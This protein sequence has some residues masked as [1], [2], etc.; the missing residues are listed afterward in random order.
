MTIINQKLKA[1][2]FAVLLAVL[3]V[4]LG[5]IS[6]LQDTSYSDTPKSISTPL[7]VI[8]LVEAKNFAEIYTYSFQDK[9]TRLLYTDTDEEYKLNNI[10]SFD[11]TAKYLLVQEAKSGY[12]WQRLT[13]INLAD[14]TK[15]VLKD[16]FPYSFASGDIN[17]NNIC[18]LQANEG[19]QELIVSRQTQIA[20]M[21]AQ[22]DQVSTSL[23]CN[24]NTGNIIATFAEDNIQVW[25]DQW[26][27]IDDTKDSITYFDAKSNIVYYNRAERIFAYNTATKQNNELTKFQHEPLSFYIHDD[28]MIYLYHS[29]DSDSNAIFVDSDEEPLTI[30]ANK[31]IGVIL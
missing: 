19:R 14:A 22:W 16:E 28:F 23:R 11:P 5:S 31:I 6:Y 10:V 15:T 7:E 4:V 30:Q 13:Q 20:S 8:Y 24:F 12:Q 9:K 2:I 29:S 18:Y 27:I 1:I 17:A 26:T 21:L 3:V 25:G